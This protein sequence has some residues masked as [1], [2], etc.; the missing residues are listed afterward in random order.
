MKYS[1]V[2]LLFALSLGL[3]GGITVQ[4]VAYPETVSRLVE[5]AT[6][7]K[8]P[9]AYPSRA[10]KHESNKT[11]EKKVN[12]LL[13]SMT[14]KEK[15]SL[16]GGTGTGTEGNAG[17]FKGVPRLGVPESRM[18]D[19]PAGVLSLHDT[20]NPP[21]E[22]L[23]AA[24]WDKK[25]AYQYGK[26]TGS[27][28]K[29]IGGNVQL[30]TQ[31]DILR[32][33]FFVRGK[34]QMGEDPYLLKNLAVQETE[35]VQS[36]D[37][38]AVLKHLAVFSQD[39]TPATNT[40][41]DIS[42][43]ALHEIHLAA[44]ESAIRK[45][46]A[47]GIM[48]SYNAVN[49][50]AASKNTYLQ[51]QVLRQMWHFKGFTITDW[52]GNSEFSLNKGTDIEMPFGSNN[53]YANLEKHVQSKAAQEKLVDTAVGN[54]LR[55]YGKAGYLGLVEVKNGK[56][57]AESG[58]KTPIK[59]KANLKQL[60]DVR[61]QN[62]VTARHI[63]E[64][65]GVLLKNQ[66]HAL[67]LKKK[68]TVAMI[69]TNAMSLIS[70]VGGER[71][72]GTLFKM[73]SPYQALT[74]QL[75]KSN[76][77]GKV[78]YDLIGD[79]I[80]TSA[81]YTESSGSQ[82]GIKR[83]YG[84]AASQGS[85]ANIQGQMKSSGQSATTKMGNH[86]VGSDTGITDK[87]INFNTGTI[88]GKPN[89]T[90]L[91]ANADQGTSSSFKY[92]SH[93]AYTWTTYVQAPETGEYD[94]M[95]E[96]I[97]GAINASLNTGKS[98]ISFGITNVNQNTQW[99]SDSVIPTET[100]MSINKQTVSLQAGKR[101]KLTVSGIAQ[102]KQKDLQVRMSWVTPSQ[103]KK[104]YQAALDAAA[105][106]DTSV[107]FAYQEQATLGNSI[108]TS[109]LALD[110]EQQKLI[111]DA[112]K[113]AKA[114]G[115][116]VVVVLNNATPV[117]MSGWVDQVDGILEMYFPGQEGG[118]ATANL[119]T[120][121]VNPSGKLAYT[122]PKKDTD[123]L[124]THSQ[125]D[126]D[127]NNKKEK[128]PQRSDDYY[129]AQG[130][131]F[132]ATTVAEAKAKMAQMGMDGTVNTSDYSEGIMTGYRWYD[133]QKV[134]PQYAF[135]HGLSY[136]KFKYRNMSVK[137]NH[138]DGEKSG[139]DVTFTVKNI[140]KRMGTEIAQVYLG[141]AKVPA[142]VQ[143]ADKQLSAFKRIEDLKAGESRKVTLHIDER[144]LSYWNTKDKLKKET[145]G[146]K[147]KWKLATG[148]RQVLVGS[149][150][151]HLILKRNITVK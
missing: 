105:T 106:Y 148:K 19:G 84:V 41:I 8:F 49:G 45:G 107:I 64:K 144:S 30:G 83:T 108:K 48:S 147:G 15:F 120:G 110:Q 89:K 114:N 42:E 10:L 73:T 68:N 16:L 13:A 136:S 96:G 35:G 91:S 44:F 109:S 133:E 24:T 125:A 78:G 36:E 150:S 58:R 146:T 46:D 51:K 26:I 79:A 56:A 138:K 75:G 34:D 122:I 86:S 52:G 130:K 82:H 132:G 143:I 131:M 27:E 123:T 124:L 90:Y 95:L 77:T 87:K 6:Q 62:S 9:S 22:E 81:F 23:L 128:G 71:S 113:K 21:I 65:G 11:V 121:K 92:Q 74:K 116:K 14:L 139:F 25:S 2:G 31:F 3:V 63:A 37:V 39:A 85:A 98:P 115:H 1:K 93:A 151:D 54:V 69:G 126:W 38:I 100:G 140:S 4:P 47:L 112:T 119:L 55:S 76:V 33:Y 70:G 60:K 17:Y 67:P 103:K 104:N 40:N 129:L 20:T 101:Y 142:G 127:A 97:G 137:E 28:N 57:V 66:N 149:S 5:A 53:T 61:N 145:D 94:L 134:K 102:T 50:T 117:T 43:Q 99:P 18:Y 135:G 72:W 80:P 12:A 111:K 59:L 7:A 29:A 88:D 141:K 32:S 118:I